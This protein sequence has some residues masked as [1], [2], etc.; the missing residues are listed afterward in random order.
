MNNTERLLDKGLEELTTVVYKM[1]KVAEKALAISINGFVED[2]DASEDVHELSEILV[3]AT[4]DV[5]EKAFGLIAKYQPVA[6]DLRIINSYMKVAYDFE[7][8]GRYAWDITYIST[9]LDGE[10]ACGEWIFE[11][12]RQMAE[13][14][15]Q[16]V[17]ISIN[18][19]KSLDTEL[20]KAVTKTEQEVD[21]MYFKY[22]DKLVKEASV[23]N[24][25]TISSVLVV[26]YLERIADHAMH[27]M[28]AVVYVTTGEKVTL[29]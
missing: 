22:L 6:S 10:S 12:I 21:D 11:Y 27:I 9:H 29:R 20:V 7:R 3:T 16:M 25:C 26:R 4:V 15:L 28:E 1:G 5:E 24:K 13:K 8:F 17:G 19:L 18:S 23:T 14:V 2:R